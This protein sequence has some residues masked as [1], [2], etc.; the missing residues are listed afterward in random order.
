[1]EKITKR[2]FLKRLA[3][4]SAA[5][6]LMPELAV[7]GNKTARCPSLPVF[8]EVDICVLGG[9]C[10]GVF[11]AVR[12]ARLGYSVAIVEQ[13]GCF[14]G[15][16]T[17]SL[18]NIWHSLLD[19]EFKRKIIGG[20]T[21]EIIGR[22]QKRDAVV[23]SEKNE[24]SGFTFNSQELKIELD[25][26][27]LETG[28]HPYL[29][30][31]F[32]EPYFEEGK[33]AGV[34]VDSKSGRGIIKARVLVDATGDGD[35]CVRLGV[36]YYSHS[37]LQ[38]PTT[39]AYME[40]FDAE[41][42]ISL[43]KDHAGE[44][45]MRYGFIWGCDL[46]GTHEKM[47]SGTRVL[48]Q[49]CADIHGLTNAEIEGRRQIRAVMDMVRKYGK[50][51]IAL[52]GLPAYIGIRETRHIKCL[53]QVSDEDTMYGRHFEDAIANGSYRLDVHYQD[54][55]GVSFRYLD[56]KEVYH[57]QDGTDAVWSR[58]RPAAESS[59]TFYQVPLRSLIPQGTDNVILAGRMLDAAPI[60]YSG[61]RVMVNMNQ[62]GEAA[63]VTAALA[64]RHGCPICKVPAS[65]VRSVLSEG[66]SIMI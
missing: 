33:P 30:V 66:N 18:V 44:F 53:Y 42:V 55:S 47:I 20:L 4:G 19:T 5:L 1:M 16:A 60:A 39:C 64:L 13:Q 14:G 49:D 63:G 31:L 2:D 32:S 43:M 51:K 3:L 45:D 27:V 58:W 59:P 50:S 62:V 46:P 21:D 10:T 6:G 23:I 65:E 29:H 15:V 37:I 48:G 52:A 11:A 17:N 24:N 57:P 35:L 9:S 56:G 8:D 12:A 26:L 38:P 40:G 54:R 28:I 22:L 7:A 34:I 61:I 41:E 25:E 36:P